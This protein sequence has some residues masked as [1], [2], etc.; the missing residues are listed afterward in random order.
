MSTELF[1]DELGEE[2]KI[3][4]EDEAAKSGIPVV[5]IVRLAI[6]LE[7]GRRARSV[8]REA[9]IASA[10]PAID[11]E[12]KRLG[13]DGPTLG[14][15]RMLAGTISQSDAEQFDIHVLAESTG[16][17][18]VIQADLGIR[19]PYVL[20]APVIPRGAIGTLVPRLHIPIELR[21]IRR[22]IAMGE[23]MAIPAADIGPRMG[24]ASEHRD[25]I[26]A[27]VDIL[28]PRS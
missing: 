18:C 1:I 22:I 16:H 28:L 9:W 10:A 12:F 23:M 5:D 14:Q 21:G 4:L 2:R 26:A 17:V 24:S 25:D 3:A 7:L 20:C 11:E 6:D 19:M 13:R 8:D 15:Y 27:A